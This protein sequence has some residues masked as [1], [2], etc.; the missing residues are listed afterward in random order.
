V[1]VG[2]MAQRLVRAKHKIRNAGIPY[3]VPAPDLLPERTAAVLAVVYLIFNEGYGGSEELSA[4][5]IWLGRALAELMPD[6]PE[7][8]GLLAL[9]LLLEARREAR[10][11]G[12]EMVLLADQDRSLWDGEGIE[13]GRTSLDR[14]LALRGNGP[15]AIQAAIAS[16]HAIE[17]RDWPQIAALYG[18]L[19]KRTGSPVVELNRAA[20]VAEVEGPEAGLELIAGLDAELGSY[21]YLHATRADFLRRLERGQEARAAYERALELTH[22]EPDRRFLRRRLAELD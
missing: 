18:D 13:A 17:P 10:F 2:T 22:S 11:E 8:H 3:R 16:L 14:A 4:E 21:P 6:E 20:A 9:M 5:A 19:A 1:P 7:V 12:E 15:Y